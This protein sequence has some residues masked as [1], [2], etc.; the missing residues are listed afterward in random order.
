MFI[1]LFIFLTIFL[2]AK[3]NE[4]LGLRIGFCVRKEEFYDFSSKNTIQKTTFSEKDEKILQLKKY[5]PPFVESS[6]LEKSQK[7]FEII[8]YAYSKGDVKSLKSLLSPR[9]FLAFSMAI[10]DRKKRGETLEGTLIRFINS[11]IIDVEIADDDLFIIVQFKTEQSNV[12]KR[13]DGTIL[14]G[15]TDFVE[16]CTEIWV[17]SRKKLS[18][19][20][21]W[22][23]YEIK[24]E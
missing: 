16:S 9:L 19:D 1:L 23:L 21:K 13:E 2:L 12:L 11:E 18:T 22:Y 4:I 17:F 14:E 7:A 6:F 24:S 3:L 5:Y 20:A 10:E 8:F 15:N